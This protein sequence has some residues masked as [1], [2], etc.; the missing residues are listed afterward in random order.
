M[1]S[2]DKET[3][4][5]YMMPDYSTRTEVPWDT[6]N[7]APT[8]GY[9]EVM[10]AG[11]GS[12]EPFVLEYTLNGDKTAVSAC[13]SSSPNTNFRLPVI[14]PKGTVYS[15]RGGPVVHELYFISMKGAV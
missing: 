5:G 15:A 13:Y 14:C 4:M 3:I 6:D 10:G 12:T 9:V 8:D 2:G 1:T 7:T 11:D